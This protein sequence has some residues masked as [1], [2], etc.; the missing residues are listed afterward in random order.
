MRL[1]RMLA[2]AFGLLERDN[3]GAS[4]RRD[5][6]TQRRDFSTPISKIQ[7]IKNTELNREDDAQLKRDIDKATQAHDDRERKRQAKM[8]K[9]K[10]TKSGRVKVKSK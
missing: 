7:R 2:E 10:A 1:G 8:D 6:E 9:E 5:V 4:A 3:R